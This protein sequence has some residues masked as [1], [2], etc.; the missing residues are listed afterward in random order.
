MI[1][2]I[3]HLVKDKDGSTQ[4]RQKEMQLTTISIDNK[5]CT[6]LT[7]IAYFANLTELDCS[8]NQLTTLDVSKNAKLRILRCYNNGMEKL[9]LGDITHLTLLNCDDN[10]LTELDVS[11]NPDL[12]D[13]ECR[14]N[15]LR[16]AGDW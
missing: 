2:Q 4:L 8:D 14:E 11:K 7:G 6:D 13:L 9:N 3:R 5:N 16:R 15:K 10:N 12:K 1:Q